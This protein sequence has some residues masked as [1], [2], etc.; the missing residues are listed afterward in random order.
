MTFLP[1]PDQPRARRRELPAFYYLQ[2]FVEMLDFV[3]TQYTHVMGDEY[4]GLITRF[5]NLDQAAQCLY[6]RL[7]NRKGRIHAV[8]KLRYAEIGDLTEPLRVLR[9][10]GW[11]GSPGPVMF[12]EILSV[13]TKKEIFDCVGGMFP[14]LRRSVKKDELIDF[15]RTNCHPE[16]LVGRVNLERLIV[17][18]QD[19][20]VRFLLFLY[21][22]ESREELARFTMRDM[23]LVQTHSFR[24]SYEPRFTDR[25]EALE[26]F[27]FADRARRYR[28]ATAGQRQVLIE[29]SAAWPRPAS[30]D[31]VRHRDRLAYAMGRDLERSGQMEVALSVFG[32]GGSAECRERMIRLLLASGQRDAARACLEGCLENPDS[33]E[34]W[35]FAQELLQQKFGHKRTSSRTDVLRAAEVLE[36]DES[37]SGTPE[38]AAIAHFR[39][40]GQQA[41][42]AENGLW[43]TLFGLMF[44]DELFDRESAALHSPFETF[45]TTLRNGTFMDAHLESIDAKLDLLSGGASL[46][47]RLL[48]T[49]TR[50]FGTA[51]GVFRWR[52]SMLETI[53]A[54]LDYADG[55]AVASV[56]REM[57]GNF[58]NSRYGYP[59]LFLVDEDGVR[60]VEIKAE[61]DQLRR[62]QLLRLRQ[63][64]AAGFR[65]DVVRIRWVLDPRQTYVVVD[66]ETTGGSGEAHRVTEIAAVKV[67][68]GAI[69]DRYQ[70]LLNPQRLIPPGITRLTGISDQMVEG[71]PLFAD[72]ADDFADFMGDAIFVAH[73]VNFDYGFVSREYARLGRRF[74]HVKLCTCASMR[75]V[76]PGHD[77]YSLAALCRHFEIELKQHH[78]ALCDAEA[79][80]ELLFL[81]NEKRAAT[82]RSG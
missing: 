16:E 32:R 29:E 65:A 1:V 48:K 57:C 78:R 80:A 42:R 47:H 24:D 4:A 55:K 21:F 76:Y 72:I 46:K 64:R 60:F 52:R 66:V 2:H 43:R 71:A 6:V 39:S 11:I 82:L 73:N 70:T 77:S 25:D 63:M 58:M 49:S 12:E 5:R 34:E 45:P 3:V 38:R 67:C 75:K 41:F 15:V 56:L 69:I 17:Q 22:G 33:E 10:G 26:T 74:R 18:R 62:N 9:A 30:D 14:G 31:A 61:G 36:L 37:H 53:F 54:L 7:V 19:E 35:F 28:Q 44:W 13:L 8:N 59:D 50:H 40:L 81:V 20:W 68:A 27:Y 79:A 23:G 51:N